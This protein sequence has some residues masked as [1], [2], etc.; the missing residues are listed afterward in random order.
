MSLLIMLSAV[1]EA[2]ALEVFTGAHEQAYE[3]KALS[4]ALA[5]PEA[6]SEAGAQALA[7]LG[8]YQAI[9]SEED[10][11]TCLYPL[12]HGEDFLLMASEGMVFQKFWDLR[13]QKAF[14]SLH[15]GR[16]ALTGF[17]P[18]TEDLHGA[19]CPVAV[20]KVEND[21]LHFHKGAPLYRAQAPQRCAFINP[22]FCFAKAS[23]FQCLAA[24]SETPA[25]L[26][27]FERGFTLY[28]LHDP[29]I[30]TIFDQRIAPMPLALMTPDGDDESAV[31]RFY[32][33]YQLPDSPSAILGLYT[34]DLQYDMDVSFWDKVRESVRQRRLFKSPVAPLFVTAFY[35]MPC[36]VKNELI[37]YESRFRNLARLKNLPLALFVRGVLATPIR[38][39]FHN[40]YDYQRT[41]G[42][43]QDIHAGTEMARFKAA[44][45]RLLR[46]AMTLFPHHTHYAWI[47]LGY[48][49][50]PVYGGTA[51]D[52]RPITGRTA[53]IARVR[54]ELDTTCFTVPQAL[55]K[56]MDEEMLKI[57][58]SR[59]EKDEPLDDVSLFEELVLKKGEW[60]TIHDLPEKRGLFHLTMKLRKD[61]PL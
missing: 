18:D 26:R 22:F 59:I 7:A 39:Y 34:P 23:F 6:L 32:D 37:V 12:Y 52:M 9:V 54:G 35:D 11:F 33:A 58:R 61:R 49:R 10:P 17:L 45:L 2:E 14:T 28:T 55:L 24:E 21:M 13:L 42:L 51:V 25:F 29:C 1:T 19:V 48:Q 36:P 40:V 16:A 46:Q 41:Y 43:P 31:S 3:K 27:P 60:F 20:D 8:P 38:R 57:I 44:K 53:H 15:K 50:F 56:D 5:L 30:R 4:F 47:D